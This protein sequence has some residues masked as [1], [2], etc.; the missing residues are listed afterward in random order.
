MRL[1]VTAARVLGPGFRGRWAQYVPELRYFVDAQ[2]AND[3]ANSRGAIVI[4]TGPDGSSFFCVGTHRAELHHREQA[5]VFPYAFLP[6]EHR[7]TRIKFDQ[8][9][10]N[11]C[12]RQRQESANECN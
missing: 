10:S 1:V 8:Y 3:L 4:K 6:V 7:A 11:D 12:N 2:L 9:G 5:A